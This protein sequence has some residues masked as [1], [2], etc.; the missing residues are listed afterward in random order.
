MKTIALKD[1]LDFTFMS[2]VT[3]APDGRH[4]AYLEHKCDP[5]QDGYRTSVMVT[6]MRDW[7][8]E[9]GSAGKPPVICWE[10]AETLIIG[11]PHEKTTECFRYQLPLRAE[12]PAFTLPARAQAMVSIGRSQYLVL[13]RTDLH[14]EGHGEDDCVIVSELPVQANGTGYISGTRLSLSLFD[15]MTGTMRQITPPQFDVLQFE[16]Y[17][18]QRMVVIS[19]QSFSGVKGIKGGISL[20]HLDDGRF[21]EVVAPG[22]YRITYAGML[23]GKVIFA[24]ALGTQNNIMENPC[25]YLLDPH[26][27]EVSN[28]A[29]PD[30]Y[31]AGLTVGSDCRYGS[32]INCKAWEGSLY[33]TSAAEGD[34][35][36]FAV[37]ASGDVRRVTVKPGSVDCFDVA[38]GTCAAV[39]MRDMGLEE[40]YT[41]DLR[42]GQESRVTGR[43]T[44][45]AESHA[46]ILPKEMHIENEEGQRVDG[47]VLEP[48]DY[49]PEKRYPGILSIHGGP[50]GSYGW[51]YY[52][53]MQLMAHSGYFVFFCNPRGSDG[54]GDAFSR[55]MTHNGT[56]DFD[57]LMRFTDAVLA[58]YPQ[59]DEKRLGVT[60]GS[61]GGFMTNWIVG[62]THRFRCASAQRSIGD[63]IVH[64]YNCDTGY[65]VTC[66]NFPPNAIESAAAAW[67]GS[68]AKEAIHSKTPLLL[69]HSDKDSR[70]TLPEAMAQY[71]ACMRAGVPVRMCLFHGETHELSRSGRPSSRVKRL[72]EILGWFH[73]YL[74]EEQA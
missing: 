28:L 34:T 21:E 2:A 7:S 26:S 20:Y 14:P 18:A 8:A 11:R 56:K 23:D 74:M 16:A 54:R 1:F 30:Q 13:L 31:I 52:H 58:A 24:G 65:W 57:D 29:Y 62:H 19:G 51:V 12:V 40:L 48:A 4:A 39:C 42:T 45:Y 59:I 61:Y 53:E 67:N 41:I 68:P 15:A 69:I 73:T 60:G 22:K 55:I 43:N 44:G 17:A 35:H 49:T 63:W 71:A 32:G 6:N 3:I 10:N 5:E 47:W 27:G 50:K 33:F 9:A 64:E 25:L 70:C 46:V 66:E 37:S 36:L 72:E 38:A